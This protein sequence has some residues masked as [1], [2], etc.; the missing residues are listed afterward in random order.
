MRS[1][2]G[3]IDIRQRI[4][5]LLKH[6]KRI[7]LFYR[8]VMSVA[9]KIL[10]LFVKTDPDLVL[11]SSFMGSRFND[12]PKVIFDYMGQNA[13]YKRYKCVWAFEK[14]EAYP[15]LQ[16][17]KIDTPAYFLTALKAKYW[18]TNTNIERGLSFKKRNQVYL[19]TWHGVALKYIGNDCPGRKDYSFDSVDYLCV[20]GEYD[21]QVFRSAFR[22]KPESY[23][24]CGMPRNQELWSVDAQ[25]KEAIREKLQIPAGKKVILYAPT[26]RDSE[27][28]GKTYAIKPPIDFEKW[29]KQLGGEYV[30]LFR[31]HHLTTKVLN[32]RFNDFVWDASDY[33]YVNDLMIA[34]DVLITDYS[35]IAFDYSILGRP[36]LTFAYDYEEYLSVRGT[37]FDMDARY[38]NRSC[39]TEDELL[40]KLAKLDYAAEEQKT[41]AFRKQFIEYGENATSLC[42]ESM[43]GA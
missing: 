28:K 30:L 17:V 21:E 7:Q 15:H 2:I 25:Q 41:V 6:N 9:F 19:N 14:P 3:G 26:W 33:P 37:Y 31:A 1:T 22:A 20:S 12:S 36:I 13:P 35:A 18:V 11:F 4:I 10:G 16:T 23:L 38:P 43:F 34:S 42:V 29:E 5:Y 39:R 24:R 32:V 27:D 40:E 8:V